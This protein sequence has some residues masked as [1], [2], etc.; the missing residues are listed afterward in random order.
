[1]SRYALASLEQECNRTGVL[2][3]G[4]VRMDKFVPAASREPIPTL[5]FSGALNEPR[6]GLG[7]LLQA[8]DL[9]SHDDP[10]PRLWLSGP[11]DASPVLA[12]ATPAARE[13]V[14]VLALGDPEEQ[15]DRYGQAWVTVLPSVN[16]SFGMVLL[17]SLACGTPIVAAN[18]AATPELVLPGTGAVSE[19]GDPPSLAR[20][21]RAALDLARQPQTVEACRSFAARFD[22]DQAL[23]PL[24]ERLYAARTTRP[25]TRTDAGPFAKSQHDGTES[26]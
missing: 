7:D 4:G 10:P 22:W 25:N 23:A 20:A 3:P 15:A 6:K 16:D 14:E 21:I 13:H 8:L 26:E 24:L 18:H 5:L 9:L 12:S 19:P 11:G 1:M 2:I 17:E